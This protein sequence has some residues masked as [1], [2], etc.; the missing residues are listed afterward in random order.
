[1][2]TLMTDRLIKAEV[3]AVRATAGYEKQKST[4]MDVMAILWRCLWSSCHFSTSSAH[5]DVV[6]LPCSLL[7]RLTDAV[8]Y[9]A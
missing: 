6:T 5:S 7:Q 1:M 4:F 3:K 8:R 2:V 9:A